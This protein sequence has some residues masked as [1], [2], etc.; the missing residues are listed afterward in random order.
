MDQVTAD[1]PKDGQLVDRKL[2]QAVLEAIDNL[3]EVFV[4]FDRDDR[5]VLANRLWRER[6]AGIEEF[7]RRGVRFEDYIRAVARAGLSP[8][9]A[10]R[11]QK[12]VAERMERHRNPGPS[13]EIQ[14]QGGTW[15]LVREQR[16]PDGGIVITGVDIT[17]RRRAEQALQ[18]SE[19]RFKDFAEAASD[20]FW[21]QDADLRFTAMSPEVYTK[22]G[23]ST[24][25]HLG[26]TR[27]ETQPLGVSEEQW[28]QHDADLTA[29]RP[30]RDFRFHRINPAGGVRHISVSGKPLFDAEGRFTGYRGIGRD[31]TAEVV[32]KERE[33]SAER[34]FAEAIEAMSDGFILTDEEG[35]L[36]TCNARYRELFPGLDDVLAPGTPFETVLRAA[37]G[38][39]QIAD[40]IGRE[41]DW[42]S[43]HLAAHRDSHR[44]LTEQRLADGKW[45]LIHESRTREGGVVGIR[46]DITELKRAE[47]RVRTLSHAVEQSP[48]PVMITDPQGRI[49]YV[50]RK[51]VELTGYSSEEALG[52]NARFLRSDRTPPET[53]DE[54]WK[55]VLAGEQWQGELQNSTKD[56]RPYWENLLV[57]PIK[58][59]SGDIVHVLALMEDISPRKELEEHLLRQAT[60]DP[61]T[62][63][64]NRALVLDRLSQALAQVRRRDMRAALLFV[65]L[66]GFKQVN[67]T[68]GHEA[69][70]RVLEEAAARMSDCVREP[71]T[72]G[73]LGGDEFA[74]ILPN[75]DGVDSAEVVARKILAVF[76]QPF[77]VDRHHLRLSASI[78][79]SVSPRHGED[80]KTLMRNADAAMYRVKAGG[81]N[82]VQVY[83]PS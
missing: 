29:R 14:R 30:F 24:D 27:R 50:N 48:A 40:A 70:D 32:A 75:V 9:A 20:W 22:T 78:G 71:D 35:R 83:D 39:G 11:E 6:N 76:D 52:R 68:H 12:W 49:E 25:D 59:E 82:G 69:G 4:L 67:D 58:S 42:L 44:H 37:A 64:P 1:A 62:G 57:S 55:T 41:E 63:L 7:T 47:D 45:I 72:V 33:A 10:G 36:V 3:Q 43:E 38:Q 79:V 65:D 21:E 74:V 23:L 77:R 60:F 73:R 8:R 81:R 28:R 61:V 19:A 18:R 31:I 80:P 34:R 2:S 56:G 51:F 13:F 17:E 66:D 26:K 46:T 5:I 53:Y 54:L 15:F 16:L